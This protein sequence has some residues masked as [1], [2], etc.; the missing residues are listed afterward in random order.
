[1]GITIR[2]NAVDNLKKFDAVRYAA[3]GFPNPVPLDKRKQGRTLTGEMETKESGEFES[4]LA[5]DA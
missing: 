5:Y 4:G 2:Q 1:M 3:L